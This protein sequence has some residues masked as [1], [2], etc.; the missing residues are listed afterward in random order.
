MTTHTTTP[1]VGS[2]GPIKWIPYRWHHKSAG[3]FDGYVF[4]L[5]VLKWFCPIGIFWAWRGDDFCLSYVIVESA[6]KLFQ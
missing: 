2:F 3:W 5:N 1:K 6:R 4:F